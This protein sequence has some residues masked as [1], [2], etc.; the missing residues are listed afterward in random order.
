MYIRTSVNQPLCLRHEVSTVQ[1]LMSTMPGLFLSRYP[2]PRLDPICS[3]TEFWENPGHNQEL[4]YRFLQR[5]T[6]GSRGRGT[7]K[8]SLRAH[9][10]VLLLDNFPRIRQSSNTSTDTGFH[11]FLKNGR[12]N[13]Q[14]LC[15]LPLLQAYTSPPAQAS[16]T[17]P[18]LPLPHTLQ[19]YN[20]PPFPP[21]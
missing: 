9:K 16:T 4:S 12:Q 13:T 21:S 11:V 15:P 6:H 17:A 20:Q 1:P 3:F 18:L 7:L 5:N 10:S 14:S 2:M 19:G 8:Q